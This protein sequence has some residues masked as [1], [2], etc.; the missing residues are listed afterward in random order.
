MFPKAAG[1]GVVQRRE[2]LGAPF[3]RLST[4]LGGVDLLKIRGHREPAGVPQPG[5]VKTEAG[6]VGPQLVVQAKV[7]QGLDVL[8]KAD[9]QIGEWANAAAS[10]L[11]L[12]ATQFK[13]QLHRA[14]ADV[15]MLLLI[16]QL[17]K[18]HP[19]KTE[20]CWLP[21]RYEMADILDINH[22][23]ASRIIAQLFRDGALQRTDS[24]DFVRVDWAHIRALRS[25]T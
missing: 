14:R 17:K 25:S 13:V 20:I 24:K 23:T 8:A 7:T 4:P 19:E 1:N 6:A 10:R 11:L 5:G 21:S 18:L 9:G 2:N 22:A 12:E 15:K 16:E 3:T